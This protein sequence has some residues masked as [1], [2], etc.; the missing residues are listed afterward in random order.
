ME[1]HISTRMTLGIVNH[2]CLHRPRIEP[3]SSK[4]RDRQPLAQE[5]ISAA[6]KGGM[7]HNVSRL[8]DGWNSLFVKTGTK[9]E[10]CY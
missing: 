8:G 5:F 2:Q 10:N 7:T 1:L 9:A 4:N 3:V 6:G